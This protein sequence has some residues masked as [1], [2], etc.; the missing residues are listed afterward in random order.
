MIPSHADPKLK[1]LALVDWRLREGDPD[2][3]GG[4]ANAT[5]TN[6]PRCTGTAEPWP[7]FFAQGLGRKLQAEETTHTLRPLR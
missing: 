3:R 5:L 1:N 6:I 7:E 2:G 4:V